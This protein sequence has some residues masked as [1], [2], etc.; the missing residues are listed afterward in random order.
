MRVFPLT[1]KVS[2]SKHIMDTKDKEPLTVQV[3]IM[4]LSAC[5]ER[6]LLGTHSKGCV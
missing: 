2:Q 5:R 3:V 4:R 1:G 6:K